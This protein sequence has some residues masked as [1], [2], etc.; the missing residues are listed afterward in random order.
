MNH[1]YTYRDHPLRHPNT[2][3]I[4][5]DEVNMMEE[6]VEDRRSR[7][8]RTNKDADYE[9]DI[10]VP[11]S[12]LDECHESFT[13]A[14]EKRKKA[15]TDFFSDTGLMALLCRH[16]QVLWLVN[17]K[18]AGEKQHYA[19]ALVNRLFEHLPAPVTVGLLYDIGCQFHRSCIKW[20]F[21]EEYLPRLAFAISIFHAYG[22]Q[23]PCQLIYHPR[24]CLG[25]GLSDG[26][27]CERLWS[28]L[29]KLIPSLRVSG[30]NYRSSGQWFGT[31]HVFSI[32]SGYS[33]L[34][35]KLNIFLRNHLK[36]LVAGY[37]ESGLLVRR[38]RIFTR[39]F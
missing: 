13:A 23:W 38:S 35:H 6:Y 24:K 2:I 18:S 26:E 39:E 20:G 27:G 16:D 3:F 33:F 17:M 9:G 14:D 10:R 25:F 29:K 28:A 15:S 1:D 5:E 30:V 36:D 4:P 22:H 8:C 19:L 7:G 34:I 11:T 31:D 12:V 32:S 21:L 37:Q